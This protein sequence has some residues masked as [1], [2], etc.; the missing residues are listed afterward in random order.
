MSKNFYLL[1]T[2]KKTNWFWKCRAGAPPCQWYPSKAKYPWKA[3]KGKP[4]V[5]PLNCSHHRTGCWLVEKG[6]MGRR[7][8]MREFPWSK[9]MGKISG[10]L[11]SSPQLQR[12]IRGLVSGEPDL[13]SEQWLPKAGALMRTP[14]MLCFCS[15]ICCF[16]TGRRVGGGYRSVSQCNWGLVSIWGFRDCKCPGHPLILWLKIF[17]LGALLPKMVSWKP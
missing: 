1:P 3:C 10:K 14:R 12:C 6:S 7:G 9:W 8:E 5:A 15:A 11:P 17:I 16:I 4:K 13:P 2:Q